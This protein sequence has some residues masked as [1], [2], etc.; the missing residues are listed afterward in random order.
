MFYSTAASIKTIEAK[1]LFDAL[2]ETGVLFYSPTEA[3]Q[4]LEL[5]YPKLDQWWNEQ[6]R[7][8]AVKKLREKYAL[9]NNQ[10]L[11]L[12]KSLIKNISDNAKNPH[13]KVKL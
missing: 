7:C 5:I 13:I 8:E 11:I 4:A 9:T 1:P 3:A 2:H 6:K 12:L 10:S